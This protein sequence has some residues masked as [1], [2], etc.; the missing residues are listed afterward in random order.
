MAVILYAFS[1]YKKSSLIKCVEKQIQFEK[2]N[3]KDKY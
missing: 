1:G 3:M 2:I